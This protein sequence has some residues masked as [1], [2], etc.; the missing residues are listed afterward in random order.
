MRAGGTLNQS[1][2]AAAAHTPPPAANVS[3]CR[4]K[5][6][7]AR[8]PSAQRSGSSLERL[9]GAGRAAEDRAAEEAALASPIGERPGECCSGEYSDS[10]RFETRSRRLGGMRSLW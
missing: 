7:G 6:A 10:A 2:R 4:R 3:A 1:A 8:D 5:R 9:G